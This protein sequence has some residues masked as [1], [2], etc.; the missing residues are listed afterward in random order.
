MTLER[1]TRAAGAAATRPVPGLR[2]DLGAWFGSQIGSTLWMLLAGL[3]LLARAPLAAGVVLT[4]FALVN[5]IGTALWHAR[6]R[7]R[8]HPAMQAQL[9]ISSLGTIGSLFALGRLSGFD[10]LPGARSH[11]DVKWSLVVLAMTVVLS[12]LFWRRETTLAAAARSAP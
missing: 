10:A 3:I 1:Q 4:C 9:W 5:A 8:A 2:W 7:L 11:S 12:L 6:E